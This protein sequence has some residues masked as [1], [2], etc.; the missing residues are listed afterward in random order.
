MSV[1]YAT[2]SSGANHDPRVCRGIWKR[3]P[4]VFAA[5]NLAWVSRN[6]AAIGEGSWGKLGFA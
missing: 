5:L 2:F 3:C 4:L 6:A 1:G